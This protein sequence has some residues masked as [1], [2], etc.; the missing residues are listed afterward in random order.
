MTL[1]LETPRLI[2]RPFEERDI[3][4]F[5]RYRSDPEVA[6]YQCW[7]APYS[8]DQAAW[9]VNEMK[10]RTPG[11]P[12]NWY[13]LALELKTTREMIGD[14]AF[15]RPPADKEQAEIAFTLATLFQGKGYATEAITRLI[16][17]LFGELGLHRVWANCDPDNL[18]SARLMERVG[19]R[20]EGR[21]L[22]SLWFKGYWAGED[23]F[24]ILNREWAG[25]H[26]RD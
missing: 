8:L 12:G 18:A 3:E 9:F 24:A 23:W 25:R 15:R 17:Y 20:H 4:P 14:C 11:E 22:E 19:M 13:Q 10:T 1:R 21:F 6:R 7:E 26:S 2:L 16:D 5:S